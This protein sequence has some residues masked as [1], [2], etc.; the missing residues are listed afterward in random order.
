MGHDLR[1]HREFYRLPSAAIQVAK[2]SKILFAMDGKGG[3]PV[4]VI[5]NAKTLDVLELNST[6]GRF[7]VNRVFQSKGNPGLNN[8]CG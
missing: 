4:R 2:I 8:Q 1:I 5:G 7:V 6:E 3:D